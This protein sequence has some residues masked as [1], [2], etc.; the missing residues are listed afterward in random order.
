MIRTGELPLSIGSLK[1]N[2]CRVDLSGNVVKLSSDTSTV[3]DATKLDFSDLGLRGIA[4]L[5][6]FQCDRTQAEM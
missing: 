1:A 5:V 4:F 2:G 6:Y 3:H